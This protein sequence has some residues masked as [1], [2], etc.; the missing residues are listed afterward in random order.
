[1]IKF[2]CIIAFSVAIAVLKSELGKYTSG[3]HDSSSL[4]CK[5]A[6]SSNDK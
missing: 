5:E 3:I 1:M 2:R 6:V 4:S